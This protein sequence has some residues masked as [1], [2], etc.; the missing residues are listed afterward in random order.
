MIDSFIPLFIG[1]LLVLRPQVFTK[2]NGTATQVAAR[3]SQ[4]RKIGYLALAAGVLLLAA[5]LF[6]H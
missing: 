3:Y 2:A 1:L 4:L 5:A 6:R